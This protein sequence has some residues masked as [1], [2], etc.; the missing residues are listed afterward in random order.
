MAASDETTRQADDSSKLPD[1]IRLASTVLIV[2]DNSIDRR[3]AGSIVEKFA[4]LRPTYA[5]DGQ[6]ALDSIAREMPAVVLTDLQMP[7][8]DGLALV[9][10]IRE[11]YPRLPV[12]LMTAHGSEDVAILALR[13]GATNYVPKKSLGRELAET[14]RQV[15][16]LSAVDRHRQKLLSSLRR[17]DSTFLLENDPNLI[18]PLIHL[19]QEDLGSMGLCDATAAMRVGVALQEALTNALYHGNLEVSSDL[20]Q[21]DERE[22]YGLANRRKSEEPYRERHIHVEARLDRESATYAIEDEGPGFDTSNLDKPIDPEDLMRIGG[23]GMLL[24]RTFMDEV[25]HNNSGN[26]ITLVKR[27]RR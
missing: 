16:A 19:I 24:I 10:N 22:F 11:N 5:D 27:A 26:K 15:L 17:R 25:T 18:A 21:E 23:R 8:M 4:G 20:R 14:L 3:I 13:A 2:D 9:Q 7:S 12:I 6:Q 1:E